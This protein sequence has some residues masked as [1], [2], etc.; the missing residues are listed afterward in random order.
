MAMRRGRGEL[1]L[2]R[3]YHQNGRCGRVELKGAW[4]SAEGREKD[5]G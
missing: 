1:P 5:M 3:W 4:R 2:R